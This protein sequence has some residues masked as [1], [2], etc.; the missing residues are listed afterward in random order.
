MGLEPS[1]FFISTL[2]KWFPIWLY[3]KDGIFYDDHGSVVLGEILPHHKSHP[4][5]ATLASPADDLSIANYSK[6]FFYFSIISKFLIDLSS[7]R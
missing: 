5:P 1:K 7:I 3:W 2:G 4:F 6:L